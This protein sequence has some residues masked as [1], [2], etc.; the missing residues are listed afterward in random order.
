MEQREPKVEIVATLVEGNVTR[1]KEVLYV[2]HLLNNPFVLVTRVR[3]SP[4]FSLL[5][6]APGQN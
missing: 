2:D 6:E 4:P 1:Q 5:A 3:S